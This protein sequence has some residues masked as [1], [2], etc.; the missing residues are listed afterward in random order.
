MYGRAVLERADVDHARDVLALD[1]APPRA[2]RAGSAR[3]RSACSRSS[4]QQEL[5]RDALVELEVPRRDDDA[6]AA[7]AEHALDA[8]LARE[9]L[10]LC[11]GRSHAS[12]WPQAP[13]GR[14]PR[15]PHPGVTRGLSVSGLTGRSPCEAPAA[16]LAARDAPIAL[17]SPGDHPLAASRRASL[18]AGGRARRA[19]GADDVAPG[20]ALLR[21]GSGRRGS[22]RRC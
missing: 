21:A 13:P 16:V 11:N 6:H 15:A 4:G 1:A 18:G 14:H 7:L 12:G 10:A 8:V 5:E 2:P 9:H 20:G 19:P 22:D 17:R 3:R